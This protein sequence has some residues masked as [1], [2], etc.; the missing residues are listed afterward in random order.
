VGYWQRV[1]ESLLDFAWRDKYTRWYLI[2]MLVWWL[3]LWTVVPRWL[4]DVTQNKWWALVALPLGWLGQYAV[5]KVCNVLQEWN[6][7]E[8]CDCPTCTEQR[9]GGAA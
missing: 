6:E 3:A 9:T 4:V 1:R 8:M 2:L 5:G 7:A